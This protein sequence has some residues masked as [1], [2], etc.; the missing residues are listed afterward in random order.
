MAM[1]YTLAAVLPL[2]GPEDLRLRLAI[3]ENLEPW[4]Y[5]EW[6]HNDCRK[7]RHN[8]RALAAARCG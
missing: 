2:F 6:L 3:E 4:A 8:H 1:T 7:A 5:T